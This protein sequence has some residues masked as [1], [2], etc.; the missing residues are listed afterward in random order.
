M[1]SHVGVEALVLEIRNQEVSRVSFD[2]GFTILTDEGVEVRLER[3]FSYRD[4]AGGHR[5]IDPEQRPSNSAPLLDLLGAG[6]SSM[7]ANDEGGDLTIDFVDGCSLHCPVDDSFEAWAVS[8]PDGGKW[9]SMPG[10]G[11]ARWA[12]VGEPTS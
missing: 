8:A 11:V 5:L 9:I 6:I 10:G 3:P 1:S 12:A 4:A 2:Y 7:T